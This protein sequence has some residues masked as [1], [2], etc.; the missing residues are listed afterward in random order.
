MLLAQLEQERQFLK[1]ADDESI[2]SLDLDDIAKQYALKT[3]E[4][5]E[6]ALERGLRK[7]KHLQ[8]LE[9]QREKVASTMQSVSPRTFAN[10]AA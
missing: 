4:A 3:Q 2:F 6:D 7:A 9:T 1:Q 5:A 10:A 8:Q